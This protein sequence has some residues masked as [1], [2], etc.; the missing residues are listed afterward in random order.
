MWKELAVDTANANKIAFSKYEWKRSH[1]RRTI[2][3][4]DTIK[5]DFIQ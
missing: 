5:R 1:T 2:K 4:Q 3:W